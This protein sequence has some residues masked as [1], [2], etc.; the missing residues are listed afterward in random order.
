MAEQDHLVHD[1]PVGQSAAGV[2]AAPDRD[3]D[4]RGS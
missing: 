4:V 3:L 1:V 2:L